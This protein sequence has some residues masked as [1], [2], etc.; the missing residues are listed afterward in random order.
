M[1]ALETVAHVHTLRIELTRRA[2]VAV[3]MLGALYVLASFFSH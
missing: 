1:K 2:V 3:V